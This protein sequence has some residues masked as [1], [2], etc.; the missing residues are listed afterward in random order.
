MRI[1]GRVA[2]LASFG[3]WDAVGCGYATMALGLR[4][5]LGLLERGGV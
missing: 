2:E 5:G 1:G 4:C 3:S